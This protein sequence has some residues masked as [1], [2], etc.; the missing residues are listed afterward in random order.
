MSIDNVIA[1]AGAAEQ[2]WTPSDV[3]GYFGLL[4]SIPFILGGSQIILE[5][6]RSIPKLSFMPV[7]LCLVGLP[8]R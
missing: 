4:V 2:A 1:I 3:V 8:V 7:V 6:N 5:G